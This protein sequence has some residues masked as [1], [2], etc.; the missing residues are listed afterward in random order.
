MVDKGV[1]TPEQRE[2]ARSYQ[3]FSSYVFSSQHYRHNSDIQREAQK[4]SEMADVIFDRHRIR[5]RASV[6]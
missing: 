4:L 2:V 1:L 3:A 5:S 6:A